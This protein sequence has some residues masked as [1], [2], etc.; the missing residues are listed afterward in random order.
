[1]LVTKKCIVIYM[2]FTKKI[3]DISK[4]EHTVILTIVIKILHESEGV[5]WAKL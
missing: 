1:M 4:W 3:K 2:Y 5:N